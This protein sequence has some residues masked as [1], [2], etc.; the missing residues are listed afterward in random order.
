MGRPRVRRCLFPGVLHLGT[1]HCWIS[2]STID[3]DLAWS[4]QQARNFLMHA[5][6]MQLPPKYVLRDNHAK[7]TSQY[8]AVFK[9]SG[10][11]VFKNMPQ[12][13]NRRARAERCIQTLQVE[14][15]D[16]FVVVSHGH[17]NLIIPYQGKTSRLIG[18]QRFRPGTLASSMSDSI[19]VLHWR[20]RRTRSRHRSEMTAESEPILPLASL[21]QWP[22]LPLV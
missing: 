21:R 4:C 7:Y 13:P 5:E 6:D 19:D 10:A 14:C 18:D 15:L 1:R 3:P 2:P 20:P 22:S 11:D 12:S 9:S 16:K 8:D 17:L